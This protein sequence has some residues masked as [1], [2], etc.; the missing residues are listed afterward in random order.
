MTTFKF[1]TKELKQLTI[2]LSGA[3]VRVQT[4]ASKA[5]RN[6]AKIVDANMVVDATGHAGNYFGR[7]GTAFDT[8]LEDHVSHEMVTP[9]LAEIGIEYKGAGK[10]AH[11][12][13]YGSSNN[14]PVYDHG[15]AL[16]RAIPAIEKLVADAGEGS[17]LGGRKGFEG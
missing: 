13:V 4:A 7:P 5:V 6:G 8:G 16:W 11:I 3:P 17:V 15:K 10:L 12:I 1:D 14:A 9:L 2:D